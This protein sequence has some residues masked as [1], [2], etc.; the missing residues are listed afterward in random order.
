MYEVSTSLQPNESLDTRFSVRIIGI[1]TESPTY[2]EILR[3]LRRCLMKNDPSVGTHHF[4]STHRSSR[5]TSV[6]DARIVSKERMK[7]EVLC[8]RTALF[9]DPSVGTHHFDS[10]HRSSRATSVFDARI[11]S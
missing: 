9:S 4:D 5:A 2:P 1:C 3:I 7:K 10:T 11:V 8:P 6:F